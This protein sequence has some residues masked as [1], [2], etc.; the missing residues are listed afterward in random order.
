MRNNYTLSKRTLIQQRITFNFNS[1]CSIISVVPLGWST[2]IKRKV[3]DAALPVRVGGAQTSDGRKALTL[4]PE[5]EAAY[6]GA[7]VV[8]KCE[9]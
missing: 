4:S 7:T 9:V 6:V 8:L 5:N 3:P 2:I 1:N